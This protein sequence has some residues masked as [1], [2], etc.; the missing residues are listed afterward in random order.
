MS[1]RSEL[2]SITVGIVVVLIL[3]LGFQLPYSTAQTETL[4]DPVGIVAVTNKKPAN[5]ILLSPSIDLVSVLF[6]TANETT[7]QPTTPV[8]LE[9]KKKDTGEV[10]VSK[11]RTFA[12]IFD[13]EEKT[14]RFSF[15]RIPPTHIMNLTATLSV[16][17]ARDGEILA[18][19]GTLQNHEDPKSAV[20]GAQVIEQRPVI[21]ILWERLFSKSVEGEDIYYY[22]VRGGQV[23]TN[24][25]PYECSLDDTCINHKNPGHFPLFYYLSAI[26]IKLGLTDFQSWIALWRPVFLLCYGAIGFLL[27]GTLLKRKHYALAVF[28]LFFWLF[29]RWSLYV[30][31]VGHV[32]FFALLFLVLSL[33]T[34]EKKRYWSVF[35]L[36]ISL[37][38]KQVAIF[39]VPL[40]IVFLWTQ[41]P[42]EKRMRTMLHCLLLMSIVPVLSLA[43]FV[44]ENPSAVA[45]GLLFSAT[46]SS[47]AN[48]GA[49]SLGSFLKLQG[50]LNV[51]PMVVLMGAIYLAAFKKQV[52][53][54]VAGLGI[55]L[56][57][58][59]FN[60]V[61]FN[62][63]FLWFVPF[64]PLALA[65]RKQQ[66]K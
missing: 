35:L 54:Y 52:S 16:P 28:A 22:Y 39:L 8:L 64:V 47:E 15:P 59:A 26:S 41:T 36:S 66:L 38:V 40:Y 49:A 31:R 58:L 44:F 19:R 37:C 60:T 27:F 57:F 51:L 20:V 62:Q 6:W 33:I 18:L 4:P 1:K 10:L 24:G 48:M 17:D 29:N 2:I 61:T 56:V 45:K 46:R 30:I 25:N 65:E 3:V 13:S 32:D 42:R 50:V 14:I 21:G 55:M 63:Y 53:F 5:T 7:L 34:F 43:P 9:I 12:R 11:S 23:A